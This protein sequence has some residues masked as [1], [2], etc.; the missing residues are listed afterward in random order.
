M[1][2]NGALTNAEES[3]GEDRGGGD[4]RRGGGPMER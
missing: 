1:G 4:E 3:A 2:L